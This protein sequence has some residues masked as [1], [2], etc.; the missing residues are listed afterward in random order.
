M[1]LL[2]KIERTFENVEAYIDGNVFAITNALLQSTELSQT[3]GAAVLAA[4]LIGLA[5]KTQDKENKFVANSISRGIGSTIWYGSIAT[6][7]IASAGLIY[8]FSDDLLTNYEYYSRLYLSVFKTLYENMLGGVVSGGIIGALFYIFSRTAYTKLL[9][10]IEE[11]LTWT[12]DKPDGLPPTEKDI[13]KLKVRKVSQW[14]LK[15]WLKRAHARKEVFI[16]INQNSGKPIFIPL[17]KALADCWQVSGMPGAGKGVFNQL[18]FTQLIKFGHVNIVFNPKK[19]AYCRSAL[20]RAC[21]QAGVPFYRVDL[22]QTS[23][24]INPIAGCSKEEVFEVLCSGFGYEDTRQESSFYSAV[25]RRVIREVSEQGLPQSIPA[26]LEAAGPVFQEVGKDSANLQ[27]KLTELVLLNATQTED[28]SA[29]FNVFEHGGCILIEGAPNNESVLTLMKMLHIRSV[30]LAS[31][32]LDSEPPVNF[33]LDES[34]YVLCPSVI[35]G[36]GTSRSFNFRYSLSTQSD[37]DSEA[38]NMPFPASA[39]RQIINDDT[40]LKVIHSTHDHETAERISKHC[41]T[42]ASLYSSSSASI[43]ELATETSDGKRVLSLREEPIFHPNIIKALPKGM[44]IIT[45]AVRWPTM[46]TIP[47]LLVDKLDV[48]F[49]KAP[50]LSKKDAYDKKEDDLL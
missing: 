6:T 26:F 31:N 29:L 20:Y 16:G 48:P 9:S 40:P 2:E 19:D 42:K 1:R 24:S 11:K 18:L 33:W 30:Q 23:A 7:F 50:S 21:D 12:A 4:P 25:A 13:L 45:G 17:T 14:R 34:K 27:N 8:S 10:D 41:G 5:L 39:V 44:A 37:S 38:T 49:Y 22:T 47:T 46:V 36:L 3:V 28:A 43:N 15:R 35:N 32:R